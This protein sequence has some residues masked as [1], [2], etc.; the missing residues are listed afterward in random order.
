MILLKKISL[1][2]IIVLS[3]FFPGNSFSQCLNPAW[4]AAGAYSA[5]DIVSDDGKD[6]EAIPSGQYF[7]RPS[8]AWGHVGWSEVSNPCASVTAPIVAATEVRG[9][10][11]T[12]SFGVGTVTAHGGATI[13]ARGFVFGLTS[14]PTLTGDAVLLDAGTGV[15]DE[16]EGLMENLTPETTYYIRTYATNSKGTTYGTETSFTTKATSDCVSDCY[17]ACD[18]TDADL[19][20]PDSASFPSIIAPDD[21]VCLTQNLSIGKSVQL[22][23]MLKLCN[24]AQLSFSNSLDVQNHNSNISFKGQ[25]VYENCSELL[26]GNGNYHGELISGTV[27]DYDPTQMISYCAA[28]D[29][30]DDTQFFDNDVDVHLW[31]ATCRPTSTLVTPLPVELTKFTAEIH[32][33][34]AVL[35]WTTNSEI[36]NSHFEVELSYDGI[37]WHTIGIAQGSGNSTEINHYQFINNQV[38]S[39]VHYYRLK[40]VDF[41]GT[42][43]YSNVKYL[44][45]NEVSK[46]KSFVAYQNQNNKIQIQA[47]FNGAGE[48]F[49][50][51]TRGRIIEHLT[52]ISTDKTGLE[53]EFRAT[54]LPQGI[55]FVKIK[56]SNA[57]LGQKVQIVK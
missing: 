19:L 52:F 37:N 8:G 54:N 22:R 28:C 12:T 51:D 29:E 53:L 48:A 1:T 24:G 10:Y 26:V 45:F 17:L 25:V 55:Y 36:N 20:N 9:T 6:W 7:R 2:A 30:N 56:S 16:F 23:G 49:L 32:K 42:E 4:N 34:G 11:C 50:I 31:A 13:T 38:G 41:N 57:L 33:E 43:S 35:N 44:S 27:D 39:G 40:Q 5:G 14:N 15:G 47:I 3:I 18:M 21:T 46:P